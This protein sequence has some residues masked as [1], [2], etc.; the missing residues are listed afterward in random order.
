MYPD[1]LPAQYNHVKRDEERILRVFRL[2]DP[3][4]DVR[5][6]WTHDGDD[7]GSDNEGFLDQS[8]LRL[9]ISLKEQVYRVAEEAKEAGITQKD[10]AKA[11][12]LSKLNARV[13]VRILERQGIFAKFMADK[14]RQRV[15]R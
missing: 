8:T 3:N 4:L 5:T 11:L 2:R 15:S 12:G 13:I 6:M 10:V 1:A 7:D 9:D 14:G